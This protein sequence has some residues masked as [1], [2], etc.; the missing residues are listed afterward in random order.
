MIMTQDKARK[1][2]TRQRMAKT[3]EPYSVARH[4]VEREHDGAT[5]DDPL[6]P[7][8]GAPPR[9]DR[10]YANEAEE[11]GI[12]VAE[13]KVQHLADLADK[14]RERAEEAEE[15]V[16]VA[17]EAAELAQQAADMTRGWA[18]KQEQ[19][20]AQRRANQ[21]RAAAEE[22]QRRADHA[23]RQADEAEEAADE[24]ADLSDEA[25]D[26]P[27]TRPHRS[28]R[29]RDH[30]WA[31]P[32]RSHQPRGPADRLQDRIGKLVRRFEL[33]VSPAGQTTSPAHDEPK[34]TDSD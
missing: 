19:E 2:A 27:H 26:S 24:A 6:A 15:T 23:Q 12:T 28:Y 3:G 7:D 4:A 20:R 16:S 22:A 8:P 32:G 30:D 14:A 17:R 34:D 11:A 29:D 9:D 5:E 31:D 10:W 33:L 25:G 13:F 18:D 1:A 21:A